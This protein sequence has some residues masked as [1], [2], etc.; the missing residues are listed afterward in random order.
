M[1]TSHFPRVRGYLPLFV[2]LFESVEVD[3]HFAQN[4]IGSVYYGCAGA[5]FCNLYTST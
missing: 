2:L 3:F 4:L 1:Y 5:Y